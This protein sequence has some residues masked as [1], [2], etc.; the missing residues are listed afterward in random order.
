MTLIAGLERQDQPNNYHWDGLKRACNPSQPA[1]IF[2]YT[3]SGEGALSRDGDTYSIPSESAFLVRVPSA[4]Q[5]F[6]PPNAS[7]PWQFFFLYFDHPYIVERL[8]AASNKLPPVLTISAS[9]VLI[10]RAVNV[11][12]LVMQGLIRDHLAYELSLF[13][14]MIEFE[15]YTSSVRYPA[16]ERDR[17]LGELREHVLRNIGQR[18]VVAEV[19]QTYNMSRSAFSHRFR[20]ATGMTP[21][22]FSTKVRLEEAVNRLLHSNQTLEAVAEWTGF[23]D[24]THFCKVF[25]RHYRVSPGE[26]RKR[27]GVLTVKER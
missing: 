12:E 24:A 8:W 23:G 4:H 9:S 21:A 6:F 1:A 13:E 3:L 14:F 11:F 16:V 15:R 7:Q 10:S 18:T 27:L 20:K 17:L 2:Q 22:L 26:Y 5:Y 19:A 25:R